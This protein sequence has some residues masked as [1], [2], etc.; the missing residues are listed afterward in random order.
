MQAKRFRGV[1]VALS[2][3]GMI[4]PSAAVAEPIVASAR[5]AQAPRDVELHEGG[6]LL[7]QMLNAQ[8]VATAGATVVLQTA[9]KEVARVLTDKDG[10]FRVAGL[11]GGVHLVATAGQQGVYRLWAPRTAPPAAQ[12]G[13]MLVSSTDVVRGQC[14]CG[15]PVCGSAVCECSHTTG[16]GGYGRGGYGRSGGPGDWISNHPMLTAGAIAA[17]IAVPLAVNDNDDAPATP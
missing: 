15:T 12:R 5:Q 11:K 9:G 4:V 14:G 10:R 16:G 1:V 13:L 8:G 17:A 2:C 7:G 6:V 3:V